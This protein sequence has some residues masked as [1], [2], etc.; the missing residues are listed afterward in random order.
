MEEVVTNTI[1][2]DG[3]RLVKMISDAEVREARMLRFVPGASMEFAK[4]HCYPTTALGVFYGEVTY[5]AREV[6]DFPFAACREGK[7]RKL[8]VWRLMPEEGYR[9]S[10]LVAFVAEWFFVQTKRRPEWA[11]VRKLPSGVENFVEV[12]GVMLTEADWA[13]E[14]C[15]MVGG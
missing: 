11:F 14:K 9:L 5:P 3:M 15:L 7:V 4:V 1:S 12:E 2:V 13:L 6:V 10:E 8:A